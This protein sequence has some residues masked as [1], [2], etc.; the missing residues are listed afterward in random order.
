MRTYIQLKN[1]HRFKL[2]TEFQDDDVRLSE[3]FV[4]HFLQAF[5]HEG[6]IVFDP[7]AGY[8]TTL[9]VAEEMGR[10]PYGIEFDERRVGYARSL[11]KHP[12]NLIHG[13]ARQLAS[14]DLPPFDFS[15][16]SPPYMGKHDL[17]NP[18]TAY[19]TRGDGYDAYLQG[20]QY[21]YEQ[22]KQMMKPNARAVIEVAN[23]KLRDG[24]TTLAWDM[25]EAVSQVLH[26]E[27][28]IVVG[29]DT[30]GF[31]YDHSYCLA[32]AQPREESEMD[33]QLAVALSCTDAG[34]QV[35]FLDSSLCIDAHRSE[36]MV[37]G[38]ITVEPGHLV[39][40]DKSAA[41]PQIV[42]RWASITTERVDDG[43][44]LTEDGEAVDPHRLRA[45]FF[46]RIQT[47]YRRLA[48]VEALDPKKTVAEGYNRIAERYLAW[49]QDDPAD[50]RD[51]YTSLLLN[52]LSPGAEVLDLGCGAGVP[53]TLALARRFQVT[54]VDISARQIALARQ[55]VP[56]ARFIQA[57]M[58]QLDFP[59]ASFDAVAAF[60]AFIHVPR[61]E[62]PQLLWDIAS[63]LRPGGLLVAT[64]GTRAMKADFGEDF[65]GAPMYW[66]SFDGDTNRRLVQEAGLRLVRAQEETV[67]EHGQPVTFLW[68]VA[69]KPFGPDDGAA[70]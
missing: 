35:Q 61:Q 33:L 47:M 24:L 66:S 15:I 67:E 23:L 44:I 18:L 69:Q 20:I 65:L 58:T 34:C 11:L 17:E 57:D 50:V 48:A 54:G 10:V 70:P 4:E 60:Y 9:L 46:P 49:V 38:H 21:I 27:G 12:D 29:W 68:L 64:L 53:T 41:P 16:A 19:T 3:C 2:P 5:T 55:H 39:A 14:Y 63:W 36:P 45:E 28:E 51:R 6:D 52:E 43:Y 8:G 30:Y 7:F 37:E 42:Y 31:G 56:Q 32:F 62:H 25:A 22:M 26:F 40:V 1:T 13:D 59:P